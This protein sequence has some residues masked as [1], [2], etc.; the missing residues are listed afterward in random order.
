MYRILL[1]VFTLFSMSSGFQEISPDTLAQ[2]LK[3]NVP[4]NF[5][6]IDLRETLEI[7]TIIGS[8]NCG[9][10]NF[11]FR[12]KVFDKIVETLPKDTM[13]ILYC[14]NGIRS[15]E[16][17]EELDLEFSNIFSLSGGINSW[18]GPTL[19]GNQIKSP[20]LFP[21]VICAPVAVL[22]SKKIKSSV[23]HSLTDKGIINLQGKVCNT[24]S[25]GMHITT[26]KRIILVRSK[27][28]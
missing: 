7:K 18:V 12:T 3:G 1:V 10:Y 11:P 22:P 14:A 21:E 24:V 19:A 15:K 13:I 23:M 28:K 27:N 16:A 9:A 5:I 20:D 6:L 8:E 4:Y 2:W 26:N 25:P 17:A